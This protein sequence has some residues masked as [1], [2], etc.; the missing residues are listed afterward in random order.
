MPA[1]SW[2][3]VSTIAS[4]ACQAKKPSTLELPRLRLR[5]GSPAGAASGAGSAVAGGRCLS[6]WNVAT[7]YC[8][9]TG[10]KLR[11]RR[12]FFKD[13]AAAHARTP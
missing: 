5:G 8:P 3:P 9:E 12:P 13:G 4:I 1:V 10:C 11:D 6:S 2:R 7:F